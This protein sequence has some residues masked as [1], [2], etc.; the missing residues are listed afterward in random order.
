VALEDVTQL[1]TETEIAKPGFIG[2]R[3]SVCLTNIRGEQFIS[4]NNVES[5][6]LKLFMTANFNSGNR[7]RFRSLEFVT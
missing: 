3:D 4:G 7:H 1:L 5:L 6:R 2:S